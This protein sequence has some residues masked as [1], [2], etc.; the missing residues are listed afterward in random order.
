ML[1][2]LLDP[3]G[4]AA[5]VQQRTATLEEVLDIPWCKAS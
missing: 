1:I 5:A 4:V 2:N 3:L